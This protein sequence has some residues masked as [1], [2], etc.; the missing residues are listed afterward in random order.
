MKLKFKKSVSA[1]LAM[2]MVLAS[3][4]VFGTGV[5]AAEK[6]KF[7]VTV[8]SNI[9]E[10]FPKSTAAFDA[11]TEKVTVTYWFNLQNYDMVNSQWILTYDKTALEYDETPGVNQTYRSDGRVDKYLIFRATDGDSTQ[12][13]TAPPSIV[14]DTQGGIKGNCSK[15]NGFVVDEGRTAFVSVTF[16]V[17]DPT[18]DST[19]NLELSIMQ[20]RRFDS[21]ISDKP[22]DFVRGGEI[23]DTGID[24]VSNPT[25]SAAYEGEFD[26]SFAPAVKSDDAENFRATNAS[27]SFGESISINF[28]VNAN[29]LEGYSNPYME[30]TREGQTIKVTDYTISDGNYKFVY[31][32]IYPQLI[33][34]DVTGVLYAER[35]DVVYYGGNTTTSVKKF[36]QYYMNICADGKNAQDL[37]LRTLLVDLLNYGAQT[38]KYT[39]YKSDSSQLANAELTETQISWASS[40]PE[41]KNVSDKNYK[42]VSGAEKAKWD[43]AQVRLADT[44]QL[45]PIFTTDDIKNKTVEI[46]VGNR[47]FTYTEEDFKKLSEGQYQLICD[48]LYANEMCADTYM[49]IYDNGVQ[50][51]NVWRFSIES[52]VSIMHSL[53]YSGKEVLDPLLMSMIK[54]GKSTEAYRLSK[55]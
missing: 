54:Y 28:F 10:L 53:D 32:G 24:Y 25:Y 15:P 33:T 16:N 26:E 6:D 4:C 9:D 51:S 8:T 55:S 43:N 52:Y 22:I 37:A 46:R 27:I 1:V 48:K 18:K 2:V 23:K 13:N 14:T 38:Q 44:V 39:K 41:L 50:C 12:I 19:V 29:A 11:S 21:P 30:F 20:V 17:L 3:V 35:D 31:R 34:D 36:A 5:S 42:S 40:D 49:T 47:T 45:M 7:S